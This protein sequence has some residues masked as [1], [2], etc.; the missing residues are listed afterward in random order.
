MTRLAEG[1]VIF[2]IRT[3]QIC[4]SIGERVSRAGTSGMTAAGRAVGVGKASREA[5][6]CTSKWPGTGSGGV[7]T[8]SA[9]AVLRVL[10]HALV[11]RVI[12]GIRI[13][14]CTLPVGGVSFGRWVTVESGTVSCSPVQNAR[15]SNEAAVK[16]VWR[17][18]VAVS[19]VEL[20]RL[21][22]RAV[23]GS[24]KVR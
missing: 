20:I 16:N 15:I 12:S 23:I 5:A 10:A 9:A 18:T 11:R 22:R 24:G 17:P 19:T 2:R 21:C 14:D 3:V 4:V 7:V 8:E 1:Q 6:R 13:I